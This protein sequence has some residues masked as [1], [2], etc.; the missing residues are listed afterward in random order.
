MD[1]PITALCENEFVYAYICLGII[2]LPI[3]SSQSQENLDWLEVS[4]LKHYVF[5]LNY[6]QISHNTLRCD[7]LKKL[8]SFGIHE[9][10]TIERHDTGL[11]W[12]GLYVLKKVLLYFMI[13]WCF[14]CNIGNCMPLLKFACCINQGGSWTKF[15]ALFC[16][17]CYMDEWTHCYTPWSSDQCMS[18][19]RPTLSRNR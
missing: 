17:S 19:S 6:R 9:G 7:I 8:L 3:W 11:M 13:S 15:T 18:K 14:S 4:S 12:S 16:L 5:C 2:S 1:V 10:L